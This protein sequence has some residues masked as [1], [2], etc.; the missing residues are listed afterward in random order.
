MGFGG[1]LSICKCGSEYM[2][3]F[4][5]SP[6][7]CNSCYEKSQ[8]KQNKKIRQLLTDEGLQD[9]FNKHYGGSKCFTTREKTEK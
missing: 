3:D 4:D 5:K 1:D 9:F 8:T 6:Y 2:P 7:S